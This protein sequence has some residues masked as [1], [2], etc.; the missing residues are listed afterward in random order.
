[1]L[2]LIR[3][4]RSQPGRRQIRQRLLY[5]RFPAP[6]YPSYQPGRVLLF[7]LRVVMGYSATVF[8]GDIGATAEIGCCGTDLGSGADLQA[9]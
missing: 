9:L 6:G 4:R 2:P 8:T 5:A 3:K 7:A 1:M